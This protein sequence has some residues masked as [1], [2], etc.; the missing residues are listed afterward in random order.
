MIELKV[1]DYCHNCAYFEPIANTSTMA[2][3][4]RCVRINNTIVECVYS[5]RCKNIEDNVRK[6]IEKDDCN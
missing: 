1:A 6:E 3:E 4:D 5:V 2:T